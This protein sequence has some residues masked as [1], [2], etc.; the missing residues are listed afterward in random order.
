MKSKFYKDAYITLLLLDRLVLITKNGLKK[1]RFEQWNDKVPKFSYHLRTW[2]EAGMVT[3]RD[4]KTSTL[5][6][7]GKSYMIIG[8]DLNHAGDSYKMY[9]PL[10][11]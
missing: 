8:Y 6:D 11:G 5:M 4:I 2:G 1:T 10:I 3:V 9:N 7:K